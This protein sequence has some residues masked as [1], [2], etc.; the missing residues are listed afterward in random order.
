MPDK[1][2]TNLN[3]PMWQRAAA[4]IAIVWGVLQLTG[5]LILVSRDS[6]SFQDVVKQ[7]AGGLGLIAFA[8]AQL[9]APSRGRLRSILSLIAILLFTVAL[10]LL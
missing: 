3:M 5:L 1:Q 4:W 9:L 10:M 2:E 6:P 7:G 8:T